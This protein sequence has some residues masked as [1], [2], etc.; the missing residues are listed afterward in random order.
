MLYPLSYVGLSEVLILRPGD[1]LASTAARSPYSAGRPTRQPGRQKAR[2]LTSGELGNG[3]AIRASVTSR[4][5]SKK[6]RE[7][8]RADNEREQ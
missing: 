1:H 8:W 6:S 7:P 5:T 4:L 2:E 3:L